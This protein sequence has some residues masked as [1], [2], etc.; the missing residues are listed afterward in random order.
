MGDRKPSR[1]VRALLAA[2][3]ADDFDRREAASTTLLSLSWPILNDLQRYRD[4][5]ATPEARHSVR[6]AKIDDAVY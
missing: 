1:N 5:A 6:V 2:L 4:E 3:D